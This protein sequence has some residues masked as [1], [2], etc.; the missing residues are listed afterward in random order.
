MRWK[1]LIAGLI[2]A[3]CAALC[4][5]A[6]AGAA[7]TASIKGT[8]TEA[9]V[10]P[11]TPIM[12]T[13]VCARET[14]QP[15]YEDC[16][17][18][19]ATGEYTIENLP[20]GK[21]T[22]FFD[23]GTEC[24]KESHEGEPWI[25][26]KRH[27]YIHH[28]SAS[29]TLN[30]GEAK[31]ENATLEKGGEIE[32]TVTEKGTNSPIPG[33]YVCAYSATEEYGTCEATNQNGKYVLEGLPTASD[34]EV[35]F[36][37]SVCSE[38]AGC[39]KPYVTTYLKPVAVTAPGATTGQN[40]SMERGGEIEGTVTNA[41]I[42]KAPIE[43]MEV[44]AHSSLP[45]GGCTL[46]DAHGEYTIEGLPSASSYTV[47][48]TGMVCAMSGCPQQYLTQEIASVAV[49]A[50]NAT[51]GV[52]AA[53]FESK[54]TA[55]TSTAAPTLSGTAAVGQT[56]TCS[57]GQWAGNPTSLSYT[58]LRGATAI[59]GQ[60]GSTYVV[61]EADQGQTISC[62]VTASNAAGSASAKSNGLAIPS[63]P[64]PPAKEEV[65][66]PAKEE[67]KTQAPQPKP[68]MVVAS[69]VAKVTG[70]NAELELTC[71]G[72]SACNGSLKL[73]YMER[74]KKV[75]TRK[76]RRQVKHVVKKVT[77][78][79]ASFSLAANG[80]ETL[81]VKLTAAGRKLVEKAGKHGLKAELSGSAVKSRT[82]VIKAARK[83]KAG[84]Q[85]RKKH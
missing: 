50:P 3:A 56:L 45:A 78:A 13:G 10:V 40:A 58:W 79:K 6:L 31:T 18:T 80:S 33:M 46:T 66:P 72:G 47:Q 59:A 21:Y 53:M 39:T 41:A 9:G 48:F 68:S 24:A 25:E 82:L 20:A 75:V 42:S 26:C 52:N 77:I 17:V 71:S 62:M 28:E 49:S 36:T 5:P 22:V 19:N 38:Q 69:G 74:I 14:E 8:V 64:P 32:G 51:T 15:Y 30:E 84:S 4:V 60:A 37:G 44:C 57:Q 2:V 1:T 70:D 73:V 29:F 12:S 81:K 54:P 27:P 34:Y 85:R 83:G 61:Q 76:G 55:P 67:G 7:G 11:V 63:P 23:G 43:G 16:A 65:K 35:A